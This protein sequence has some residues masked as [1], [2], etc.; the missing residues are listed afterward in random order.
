MNHRQYFSTSDHDEKISTHI[1]EPD[2]EIK[3]IMIL[4]HGMAEHLSRYERFA[5]YLTQNHILACGIDLPGHG[6]SSQEGLGFFAYKN[7]GEYVAQCILDLKEEIIKK[8]PNIPIILFGHSMGSFFARYIAAHYPAGIDCFIFS[9]TAGPNK[10]LKLGKIL[11]KLETKLRGPKHKST[12]LN[13]LCFK[14]YNK[15]FKPNRTEFDW[16]SRDNDEVD[17]YVADP[18]CGF[19]FSSSAFY[20][21]FHILELI[22]E[23]S[24]VNTLPKDKPYLFISGTCDPVGEFGEGVLKIYNDMR[25]ADIHDVEFKLYEDGRHEMLN[26]INYTLPYTN[27]VDFIYEKLNLEGIVYE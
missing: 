17:K 14:P 2:K 12:L 11:A 7:G 5:E 19:V 24:W 15:A 23:N 25:K 10:Q 22:N 8:Y 21:F 6:D 26:E 4:C 27:I 1:W 18:K 3:A 20:D 16:L 9:G 13:D